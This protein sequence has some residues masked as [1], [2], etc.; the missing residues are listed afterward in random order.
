MRDNVRAFVE[1]A[2]TAMDPAGPVYEF[3]SLQVDA[4]PRGDLRSLFPGREFL[5]CDMRPG[6]G[7][8]RI[9]DL[10]ELSLETGSAGTVLCIDTLEHV[11]EARRAVDEMIRVLAPGGIMIVSVPMEFRVHNYPADYWRFTPACID[12]LLAPLAASLV[13][14]Q[15]QDKFPHTVFGI[16]SKAPA[17]ARFAQGARQLIEGF[18]SYLAAAQA[19][20]PWNKR[21]KHWLL[22]P[23]RS[24]GERRRVADHFHA[25]FMLNL[26]RQP[27]RS[28]RELVAALVDTTS[29]N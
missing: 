22:A 17:G 18:Q 29:G 10:G 21:A 28:R 9:E 27:E 19:A 23:L 11:F 16:G 5:G 6:P 24:R 7:V 15:G 3:G 20:V 14:W 2:V 26:P 13:V 12:R 25:R 1:A 8:D 4:D